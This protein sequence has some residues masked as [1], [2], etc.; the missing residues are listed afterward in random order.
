MGT[1]E[2]AMAA[3]A[4]ALPW[5]LTALGVGLGVVAIVLPFTYD[6]SPGMAVLAVVSGSIELFD[7]WGVFFCPRFSFPADSPHRRGVSP[8]AQHRHAVAAGLDRR[9]RCGRPDGG[10]DAV[11][12]SEDSP[13]AGRIQGVA[14]L[15]WPPVGHLGYRQERTRSLTAGVERRDRYASGPCCQWPLC[16]YCLLRGLGHRRV[17]CFGYGCCL[18]DSAFPRLP[19]GGRP[20]AYVF[21]LE[22][23]YSVIS[24]AGKRRR[25]GALAKSGATLPSPVSRL[26]VR[27]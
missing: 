17:L 3:R 2:K 13:S 8:L 5:W 1:L 24:Y 7:V 16:P 9:L 22:D 20:A 25:P 11:G 10:I 23:R 4:L 21:E 14:H 15:D 19:P 27:S 18:R 26:R 12:V 6:T